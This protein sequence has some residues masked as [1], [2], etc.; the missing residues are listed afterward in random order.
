MKKLGR[1]NPYLE[2][3]I[4][5]K[6]CFKCGKPS[7]Y[8]WN[9]CADNKYHPICKDCDIKLNE[10]VLDFMEFPNKEKL[11]EKYRKKVENEN[12]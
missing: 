7:S 10:L 3:D 6:E 4:N 9:I 11:L 5:K 1:K 8:Q 2:E 12:K